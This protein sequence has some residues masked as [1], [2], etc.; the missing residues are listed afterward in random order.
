[1]PTTPIRGGHLTGESYAIDIHPYD[2]HRIAEK[3]GLYVEEVGDG[4]QRAT[5]AL[6][7]QLQFDFDLDDGVVVYRS[8]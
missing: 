1:V 2:S 7:F 4:W 5:S 8:V 3:L 6:H